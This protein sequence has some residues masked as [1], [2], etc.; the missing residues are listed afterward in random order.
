[1]SRKKL[2]KALKINGID[3]ISGIELKNCYTADLIVAL[4]EEKH[5]RKQR[6]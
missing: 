3:S 2:I 5:E 1:M 4:R 6:T